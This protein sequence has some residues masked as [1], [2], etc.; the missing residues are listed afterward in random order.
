LAAAPLAQQRQERKS[1]PNMTMSSKGLGSVRVRHR[2]YIQDIAGSVNYAVSSFAVNPGVA[3]TFPWLSTMAQLYESYRF[4]SLKFEYETQKS[5]STNGTVLL[6]IDFDASDVAPV[7]KQQLMSFEGSVRSGVW[8]ECA[9]TSAIP[10]LRKIGPDK[11]NRSGSLAAN[12]D[13]KMYD[14]GNLFVAT[15]GCAD[16]SAIGELYVDY[17]VEFHT[18]QVNASGL[19]LGGTFINSTGV[20]SATPFGT[21]GNGTIVGSLIGSATAT[22]M[23]LQNLVIGSEYQITYGFVGTTLTSGATPFAVTGL[24]LVS[25]QA[26]TGTNQTN[27]GSITSTYLATAN[28][29]T[30]TPTVTLTAATRATLVISS[31]PVSSF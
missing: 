15:Q 18:P 31:I 6:G 12:Q 21:A 4:N 9:Y 24:T 20:A 14:T 16:A 29:G 11:Y 3:A 10:S 27:Q 19:A 2:E 7:S 13:I 1:A 26:P 8:Q 17:D 28:S 25:N 23:A 5:A 30:L 22:A